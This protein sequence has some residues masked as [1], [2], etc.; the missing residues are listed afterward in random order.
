MGLRDSW[1]YYISGAALSRG[2]SN[3]VTPRS[4][5]AACDVSETGA[6]VCGVQTLAYIVSK[7]M[8][9]F[10]AP[11][12]SAGDNDFADGSYLARLGF[13]YRATRCQ[14]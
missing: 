7:V 3:V 14:R 2:T 6:D 5:G 8:G 9:D 10:D 13:A 12:V 4:C 1:R 11:D